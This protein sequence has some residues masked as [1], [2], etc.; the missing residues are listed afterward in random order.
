MRPPACSLSLAVGEECLVQPVGTVSWVECVVFLC[1]PTSADGGHVLWVW[2][3]SLASSCV[4]PAAA[5][6]AVPRK[7]GVP[8]SS[9]C[10]CLC[11]AVAQFESSSSAGRRSASAAHPACPWSS[12]GFP[13][14]GRGQEPVQEVRP[15]PNPGE[16]QEEAEGPGQP[17]CRPNHPA[18]GDCRV[19]EWEGVQPRRPRLLC[20][21][22]KPSELC[23]PLEAWWLVVPAARA[24]GGPV[25]VRE[26]GL[27]GV[28][29]R[30]RG[31]GAGSSWWRRGGWRC[32]GPWPGRCGLCSLEAAVG[33][34]RRSGATGG[35][36]GCG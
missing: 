20:A 12:Q 1:G 23:G 25:A 32:L 7:G 34:C 19:G 24:G 36:P 9:C 27:E 21:G 33:R 26:V 3:P 15:G 10:E 8:E 14:S 18:G 13:R 35:A 5:S 17:Q 29:V 22:E 11:I 16:K 6:G 28:W 2:F 30:C 31:V 4:F